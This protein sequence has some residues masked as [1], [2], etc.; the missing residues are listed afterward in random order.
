MKEISI[1]TALPEDV[2][3]IAALLEQL[4]RRYITVEF[5]PSAEEK[6]LKSNDVTSIS[7]FIA[8][9]FRYWVAERNGTLIGFIGV[10]DD[11]HLYH[12]FVAES[13][14]KQGVARALWQTAK[15]ACRG[16]GNP[17]RFTVNS[18]NNAVGV[19]E[20]LGFVRAGPPQDADGVMFNPMVLEDAG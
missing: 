20:S 15:R 16:A 7:T 10:R 3:M 2:P 5:T 11:S 1:R 17:G 14:Q 12:L 19:Y 18:S 9:G 6:F 13:E 8:A 4:A